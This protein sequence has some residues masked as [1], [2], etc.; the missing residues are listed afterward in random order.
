MTPDDDLIRKLET[1]FRRHEIR[2]LEVSKGKVLA[3]AAKSVI[4]I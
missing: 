2:S 4:L 1:F 3:G